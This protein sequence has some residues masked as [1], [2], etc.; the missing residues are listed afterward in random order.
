MNKIFVFT[1]GGARGNPGP[2]AI[3][4]VIKSES[5]SKLAE[6]SKRIGETTN[7]FAEYMGVLEA[8]TWLKLNKHNISLTSANI[9][10]FFLDSKIVVNQLNGLYKVKNSTLRELLLQVRMLEQEI[11]VNVIYQLIPREKNW[12]ADILV[13]KAL[14]AR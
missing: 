14:D 2:A 8:L 3:G 4:V 10:E 12:E 5:G 11:A 6:I 1:D 13:N 7:N 9:V